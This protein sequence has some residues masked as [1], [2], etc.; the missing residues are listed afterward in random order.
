MKTNY[1]AFIKRVI[2]NYEGGYGWDKGDTGGPTKYGITC[3]DLAEHRGKFMNSMA[4]W[5]PLVKDM[6][7]QE[8]EDIYVSKYAT[9]LYFDDLRAGPDC[10]ILD[11]GINSGTARP[12]RVARAL[13][14][15][16][17]PSN[18]ALIKAINAADPKWFVNAMDQE[19]LH[20]MHQIRGGS[21]WERF[22]GGW[23]HRVNDLE[24]YCN[25][26]IAGSPASVPSP[27]PTTP[28]PKVVHGRPGATTGTITKTA[29]GAIASGGTAHVAGAPSWVLP[30]VVGGVVIAGVAF[31]I[32]ESRKYALANHTVV[33]P[34]TVPPMPPPVV[35]AVGV[36]TGATGVS[37]AA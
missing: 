10:C 16:T 6:P 2:E 27:A 7:L 30:A 25:H 4:A 17:D 28:H 9:K 22:G 19:R 14:K 18:P 13:L 29:G 20:F 5:A 3:Y 37:K 31:A 33:I 34:P 21:A 36:P 24:S 8:A 35:P 12:L 23:G 15:F 26:L 11:Y 32:Y 1:A